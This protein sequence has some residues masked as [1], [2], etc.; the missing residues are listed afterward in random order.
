MLRRSFLLS[1][2]LCA[3]IT[4]GKAA[5]LPYWR[6][7]NVFS[8]N[9]QAPRTTFMTYDN[10]QDA[11]KGEYDSS[12][13]YMLLNGTWKFYYT[14]DQ[15]DLPANITDPSQT[16]ADWAD[17][18]VP[19]SWEMQGYGTAVY[20]NQPYDFSPRNPNPPHLPD[21]TAVGVYRREIEVPADWDGRDIYLHIAGAKSGMYVYINGKEVGYSEDAKDPAEFLIN[22]YLQPGKNTLALKI[23]QWSTGSYLECQDF[24]RLSGIFRD[25]FLWSQPKVAVQDFRVVSTLDD[26]YKNG[27]FE[28]EV[29]VKNTSG[30][31]EKVTVGYELL[32]ASGK[33]V[34][35]A[36][37]QEAVAAGK[38]GAVSFTQKELANVAT[39]TSEH[40]NL[41]KLLITIA[42]AG[43]ATLEVIP[44]NVGFRRIEIKE[45]GIIV[46]GRNQTLFYV[47]GQPIKLKGV[48]M[49]E[50]SQVGGHYVSP[51]ELVKHM[52]LMKLHNVNSIRLSHYPQD[53][54]LYELADKYGFYIYDEANIESHGMGYNLNKGRSLGNNPAWLPAH[55][56]RWSNMFE[57]N[58][59]YPCVTIWSLGNEAG[60]GYNFY[61]GYLF[62]KEKDSKLMR[63]PVCYER[64]IWEWNT[65][66]Y[67]P[68]YPSSAWMNQVGYSGTDRPVVP[69]E[70]THAMGNSNGD[71][72]GIWDAI[73]KY[74][75]LQGGYIWEWVDHTLLKKDK[76][77]EWM[78][79]Y[80]GD[81][82]VD[83]PSDGNFVADGVIASNF[84]PNP[85]M[86]EVKYSH[87]NVG[88]R[89]V[90]LAKGE[91]EVQNRFYFSDLSDYRVK[92][93]IYK[94]AQQVQTAELNLN[95]KPQEVKVI[96]LPLEK[97]KPEAGAEY[98]VNFEVFTRKALPLV[99]AGYEVAHEQFELPFAKEGNEYKAGKGPKLEIVRTRNTLAVSS[100]KVEFAVDMASGAAIAYK[101]DGRE[102][103]KDNFGLRPNFWRGPTDN[104]YG[105][106][107]PARVQIW[108]K[109][110]R[111]FFAEACD[112]EY[113]GD[114]VVIKVNYKLPAGNNYIV[115]YEVYPSG[116]VGVKAH[117]TAL[118]GATVKDEQTL[119]GKMATASPKA[120]AEMKAKKNVLE[121][122]RIGMRFRMPEQMDN[123]EYFGRGPAENYS[124][125]HRGSM[126]GLYRAKAWDLYYPYTRPQ[127]NGH[128]MD[129]RWLAL[130][131]A[132]GKGLLIKGGKPIGFNALRNSVE[133][134]DAQESDAPYQWRNMSASEVANR[135]ESTAVNKTRKQTHAKDIK[136]R[137]FVEVCLDMRQQGVAGYDSW[138]DRGV[139][140]S[141]IFS[142]EDYVWSFTM[143]PVSGA[144]DM[145][146]KSKLN[147]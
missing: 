33:V 106:G 47:N 108:K 16:G 19:T 8:V 12:K 95:L 144:K 74:P 28:L 59:N 52:E 75:N 13:Y 64:A 5:D 45:S 55:M 70:Y 35:S 30:A 137:D 141:R 102:Y 120:A 115:D 50:T 42:N 31:S 51:E 15:R 104:D 46:Q 61:Q 131:D 79:A 118:R 136:P 26:N 4:T 41:F 142:D 77:G 133:D 96:T 3:A 29:D 147:Y 113:D 10:R 20:V 27:L 60:N 58:K 134:F 93:T 82:G 38:V 86:V 68:Q 40:P 138:G 63:R 91:V 101:V 54:R 99:P 49:H 73:Y 122:P 123:V 130:T 145:A 109:S 2:L 146:Q 24:F 97:V 32:D 111:E 18:K 89:A 39:W 140:E 67:V 57:R 110:S 139:A 124:D 80:G 53:R 62:V 90:D 22:K 135:D 14:P 1:L 9:K 98:F 129:T 34:L 92:Y 48:N 143:V 84:T 21:K 6:D 94:N 132:S 114:N 66:M 126:V 7:M 117:F 103:F 36:K 121:V 65:D 17:I 69:S 72:A 25:V 116:V 128:H 112:A 88:F 127:E 23:Y 105:N 71:L 44:F 56:E 78:R 107:N 43:G 87:Q 85:G 11:L 37:S 125:R 119:D 81:F 76:D 100:S 83:M